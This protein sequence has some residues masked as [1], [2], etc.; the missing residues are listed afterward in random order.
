MTDA[1]RAEPD[2]ANQ[3]PPCIYTRETGKHERYQMHSVHQAHARFWFLRCPTC[4]WI[5]TEAIIE[6]VQKLGSVS[7]DV[8]RLRALARKAAVAAHIAAVNSA[9][10][11]AGH[12]WRLLHEH[13]FE[14]CPH[15]D[16]VLVRAALPAA[17]PQRGYTFDERLQAEMLWESLD[18]TCVCQA[19]D[20][21]HWCESC[22]GKIQKIIEAFR[23]VSAADPQP[24]GEPLLIDGWTPRYILDEAISMVSQ[25]GNR[26]LANK[27]GELHNRIE[28]KTLWADP[29][30]QLLECDQCGTKSTDWPDSEL[31]A[32]LSC[33]RHYLDDDSCDG[34]MRA[35]DPQPEKDQ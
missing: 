32:G 33:P 24:Q 28:G 30:P 26:D 17:D 3:V 6:D 31:A 19:E 12:V 22:Q 11:G 1:V 34:T 16:C 13:G 29:Q 2:G 4:G 5:D 21:L 10:D 25:A 8:A 18:S 23:V 9:D 7:L 20:V 14:F 27:L 15:P 35:A